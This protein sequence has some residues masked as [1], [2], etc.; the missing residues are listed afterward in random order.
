MHAVRVCVSACQTIIVVIIVIIYIWYLL[1][2]VIDLPRSRGHSNLVGMNS[3]MPSKLF[4]HISKGT[5]INIYEYKQI[6]QH[7]VH[8]NSYLLLLFIIYDYDTI[9]LFSLHTFVYYNIIIYIL[10][11]CVCL[12]VFSHIEK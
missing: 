6:M 7:V 9:F 11:A 8:N 10:C 2:I 1:R 12:F 3:A 5:K 4:T